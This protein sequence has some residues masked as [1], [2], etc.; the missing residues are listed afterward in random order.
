MTYFNW[1]SFNK[2]NQKEKYQ[3]VNKTAP[4]T[5][6]WIQRTN[7]RSKENVRRICKWWKHEI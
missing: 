5:I 3:K 7:W 6:P 2:K 4:W 1:R